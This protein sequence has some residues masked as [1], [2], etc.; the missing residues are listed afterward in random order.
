[1][2]RGLAVVRSAVALA[3]FPEA[4][5]GFF[6]VAVVEEELFADFEVAFGVHADAH[7]CVAEH[8]VWVAVYD[9]VLVGVVDEAEF[10]A[11]AR[12]VDF[13]LCTRPLLTLI[14]HRLSK[15]L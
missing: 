3:L 8:D 11:C 2:R 5:G 14:Y 7:D 1:M 12:G 15:K 9:A 6:W 4:F 10:I 13:L